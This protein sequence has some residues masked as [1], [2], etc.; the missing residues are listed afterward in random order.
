MKKW[1]YLLG[2][3]A[4]IGLL[5]RLPHPARDISELKPVRVVYLYMN[6]EMLCIETDTGESGSGKDLAEAATDLSAHADGE[7]FLETAEFLILS[8]EVAVTSSFYQ[9]LRPGC[10]VC[11]AEDPPDLE[12]VADYLDAHPPSMTMARLRAE[13]IS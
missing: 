8:P 12:T 2:A 11:R 5:S 13:S 4:A 6:G 7:I 9:Y 10:M 1:L 3:V